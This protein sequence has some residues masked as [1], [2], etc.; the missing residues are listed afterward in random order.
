MSKSVVTGLINEAIER[1]ADE[2]A[3]LGGSEPLTRFRDVKTGT[4]DLQAADETLRKQ[5]VDGEPV[6]VSRLFPHEPLRS[7]AR[8]SARRMAERLW[9]LESGHGVAGGYLVT[10]LASWF[11]PTTT[12]RPNVP[13]LLRRVQIMSTGFGEPDLM[14]HVVG[15][16]ELN[17]RLL[18][19]MAASLG[20]RLS[21]ADL[22][23]PSGELRY[24]VVVDRLREQ[25]PPHVVDGFT[26]SHRA[27]IGL[28]S[29]IAADVSDDLSGS[30]Q[31]LASRPFVALAAGTGRLPAARDPESAAGDTVV[32]I[33]LDS[34]Q[35][36]VID[37]VSA[38]SSV[39]VDAA[40][41]TGATQV[42]AALCAQA[43]ADGR[44]VLVV[45]EAS[46][47]LRGL[48]RR[49]AAIGLGGATLDLSD[50][51]IS[52]P[53]L[54]RTVL[55][56]IDTRA[57]RSPS[58]SIGTSAS[59]AAATPDSDAAALGEYHSALHQ[60]RPPRGLSA[61]QAISQAHAGPGGERSQV[62][63]EP[64]ALARL[65]ADLTE[66][67]HRSLEEFVRLDGLVVGP[68]ATVWFGAVPTTTEDAEQAVALVDRLRS[69][70]IPAARD[71]AARAAVEVGMPSPSGPADLARLS[72]LLAQVRAVEQV[73]DR[74]IWGTHVDR[75]AA[76]TADRRARG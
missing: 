45:A 40:A 70:L 16:A 66:R 56:T 68:Q 5:L 36:R 10:G 73:F 20:L 1:W 60:P 54:A 76:A 12:K 4:L 2:V 63:I 32:S 14:L 26:I 65:D 28:M 18:D 37:A 57:D 13:I 35:R 38:G 29:S 6:R 61:Y 75:L 52:A 39:A 59:P 69:D 7:T 53:Q 51:L 50:G 44:S 23:D 27:V 33:D 8:R 3:A 58:D 46:P 30:A 64:A 15:E 21:A 9:R 22:L 34:S 48:R 11:D 43:V 47:R 31:E 17:T 25:A 19:A 24:P 42:A 74:K 49:L 71:H 62:R 55:S 67:L 72:G 41:G